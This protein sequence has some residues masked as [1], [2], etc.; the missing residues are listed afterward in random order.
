MSPELQFRFAQDR[1]QPLL[2]KAERQRKTCG[3]PNIRIVLPRLAFVLT[4][5]RACTA[6]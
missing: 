4:A 2:R 1:H 3:A 5:P 6:C